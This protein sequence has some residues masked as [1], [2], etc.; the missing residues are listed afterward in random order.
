[1]AVKIYNATVPEQKLEHKIPTFSTK[2]E[3]P[4]PAVENIATV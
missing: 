2:W 3:E 4:Y 1:M